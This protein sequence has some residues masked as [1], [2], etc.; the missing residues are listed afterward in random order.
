MSVLNITPMTVGSVGVKPQGWQ[1]FTDDTYATVIGS[2]YLTAYQEQWGFASSNFAFVYTTDLGAVYLTLSVS[3]AGVVTL[4]AT[5]DAQ[6]VTYPVTANHIAVFT[7]TSS[8][9]STLGDDPATAING[10]NIQAG[11]SGTAGY[12]ASFPSAAA[13]GSLR[14]TAVANTGDTLVTI[15]NALHGQAS[16]YSIPDSGAATAN[17]I[18]SAVTAG[19]TISVGGLTV[20]GGSIVAGA[21]GTAG[22]L[23]SFPGTA[24]KGSLILAAVANTGDTLTT[25]SNAAMGQASVISIPDPG[26][27]TS[28]FVLTSSSASTQSIS[29][30]INITGSNNI[31][32]LAGNLI[33]GSSGNAGTLISYP[34]TASKGSLIVSALDN[35]GNTDVTIRNA[36]HGQASV[37]SIPDVGAATGQFAVVTGALVSTNVMVASGTAGKLADGG[38][39]VKSAITAS[40]GGGGTSNAFTATGLTT[41]SIV[42]AVIV[43]SSNAVSIVKAVPTANVLTV[44]FSAD[45]GA[46]TT[47]AWIA[48]SVAVA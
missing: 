24:L 37:Y 22:T 47:V 27:A 41:S 33:A 17:F 7:A 9:A 26:A 39:N 5:A 34:T 18:V 23:K 45:P 3:T 28:S 40:Y 21:S 16:V 12:L 35:T 13:K 32:V 42:T 6:V 43:T 48:T 38:Y 14:V 1:I 36:L 4:V 30:G 15:S 31:Q 8:S 11:L 44:D 2:G 29:S 25:I 20:S 19:Q 10:G 46:A